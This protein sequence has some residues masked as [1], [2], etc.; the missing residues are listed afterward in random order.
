MTL[1][2]LHRRWSDVFIAGF[3]LVQVALPLGYYLSGEGGDERFSWRM[4]S[5]VRLSHCD[6]ALTEGAL[7]QGAVHWSRV[8]LPA[9]LPW[10][11][12]GLLRRGQE[13]V[14]ARLLRSR[15]APPVTEA[16]IERVCQHPGEGRRRTER[17]RLACH[18]D[19][20]VREVAP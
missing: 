3:L 12:V 5:S 18:A 1:A 4:F 2:P 6:V 11:W 19:V 20:V 9:V 14:I 7:R 10:A 16:V 13:A 8:N 17:Y 15:C